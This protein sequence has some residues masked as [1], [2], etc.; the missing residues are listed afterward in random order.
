MAVKGI[1]LSDSGII[2][3]L[4]PDLAGGLLQTEQAGM[5]P[6]FALSAGMKSQPINSLAAI[7]FEE[8]HLTRR[9][10]V[11]NNATTGTTFTVDDGSVVLPNQVW[12][13]ET[14]G[15]YVFV[16][17]VVGVTVTVERGFADTTNT[18]IN[19]SSTPVPIQQVGNAFE[20]ASARP[21]GYSK[22]GYPRYN[23]IQRFRTP[24][25]VSRDVPKLDFQTTNNMK[26]KNR[27]DGAMIHAEDI[28]Y[29]LHFGRKTIDKRNGK[30]FSTMDGLDPII[31][32]NVE[33]QSTAVKWSQ[34]RDFV[35]SVHTVNIKG[36]PNERITFC[37]DSVLSVVDTLAQTWGNIQL[38]P[39][40]SAFGLRVTKVIT[41]FGTIM[42]VS[43]P[44]YIMNP[45]WNKQLTMFHPGA[46]VMRWFRT[47]E[48]DTYD[49][50]GQRAGVDADFGIFTSVLTM[51][52]LVEKTA[53]KFTG[54]DTAD[55][56]D[57]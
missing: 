43:H 17:A 40:G 44:I 42:L 10:N 26:A 52:Y 50:N 47:T 30:H 25:D 32:T 4:K 3:D 34:L 23:Y 54:I 9:V 38:E 15:E 11:V 31:I 57:L 53:G 7:W 2:G 13:V 35:Q 20:E 14:T 29:S 45:V 5:A 51:E 56:V 18:T 37:G 22:L 41:P 12:M 24:W 49:E 28:E 39:G 36:T 16:T 46:V 19:G 48:E 1:F 55:V 8:A 33:S 21:S 6:F 27:R